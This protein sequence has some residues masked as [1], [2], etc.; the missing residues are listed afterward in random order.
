MKVPVDL[1]ADIMVI[2]S[3]MVAAVLA[4]KVPAVAGE[5]AHA[6]AARIGPKMATGD[7]TVI[8]IGSPEEAR[9][10]AGGGCPLLSPKSDGAWF[11]LLRLLFCWA[12]GESV[13]DAIMELGEV[14]DHAVEI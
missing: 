3:L 5:T 12:Q 7:R 13:R 8:F 6:C 1:T 2:A 9:P 4:H 10:G 11:S 14:E